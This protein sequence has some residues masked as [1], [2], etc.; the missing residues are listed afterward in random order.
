[1]G[2]VPYQP[3][4]PARPVRASDSERERAARAL[5]RHYAAGRLELDELERRVEAASTAVTRADLARL[6]SDLPKQRVAHAWRSFVEFNRL[7]LRVHAAGFG[8]VNGSL[9]GIWALVGGGEFW[10]AWSLVPGAGALGSHAWF[11]HLISPKRR[12]S[13]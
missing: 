7:A 12:R 4:W 5:R 11:T 1:M 3:P 8:V 9:I 2:G 13:R 6:F 10:P